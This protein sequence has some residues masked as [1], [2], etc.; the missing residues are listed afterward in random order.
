MFDLRTWC[1]LDRPDVGFRGDDPVRSLA[2]PVL[3]VS[4]L[5]HLGH[6]APTKGSLSCSAEELS[7]AYLV[8]W[9]MDLL[10]N[11]SRFQP[12]T[13]MIYGVLFLN[14]DG[15]PTH[16][17]FV[18]LLLERGSPLFS[19]FQGKRSHKSFSAHYSYQHLFLNVNPQYHF[20]C[21]HTCCHSLSPCDH[22]FM[23]RLLLPV[24]NAPKVLPYPSIL[25]HHCGY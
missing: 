18:Y 1:C 10:K 7:Y 14:V 23:H 19:H 3:T 4:H 22:A 11:G 15:A 9:W 13:D 17:A 21:V 16:P 2:C 24:V 20:I 8:A 25:R 5:S 6:K 12:A